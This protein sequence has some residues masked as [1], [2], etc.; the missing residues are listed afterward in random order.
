M[1]GGRFP[2]C[3]RHY[4]REMEGE[5]GGGDKQKSGS[6]IKDDSKRDQR[7]EGSRIEG[8]RERKWIIRYWNGRK[9]RIKGENAKRKRSI[10]NP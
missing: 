4:Q 3:G 10:L 5:E 6:G 2:H 8:E 1:D 7:M 9:T